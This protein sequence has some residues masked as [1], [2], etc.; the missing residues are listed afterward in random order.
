M[1]GKKMNSF[2]KH[3]EASITEDL[4]FRYDSPEYTDEG[5]DPIED[6]FSPEYF[7]ED[8]LATLNSEVLDSHTF[9]EKTL[10]EAL[11]E[12][13]WFVYPPTIFNHLA[14]GNKDLL[15]DLKKELP[16]W[17]EVIDGILLDYLV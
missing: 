1:K 4:L 3:L 10:I 12:D 9:D 16:V 17:N 2:I 15:I 6:H 8:D 7:S 5:I 11:K 14:M 13:Q